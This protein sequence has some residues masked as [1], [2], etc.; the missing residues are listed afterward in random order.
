M[1]CRHF[2]TTNVPDPSHWT[3]YSCFGAFLTI[4]LPPE[5]RRK[6]GSTSVINAQVCAMKSRQNLLQRT[7]LIDPIGPQTHIFGRFRL[8][9]HC[10]NFSAEQAEL[11]QLMH[12]FMP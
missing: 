4:L 5:S 11:V 8:V 10:T 3:P 7:H 2:F 6:T 1:S 12:K 9:H